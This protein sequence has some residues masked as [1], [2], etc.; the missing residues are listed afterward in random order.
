MAQFRVEF[1]IDPVS[2]KFVAE[3]YNPDDSNQLIGRTEAVYPTQ[4]SALLGVVDLF[5]LALLPRPAAKKATPKKKRAA[6][7]PS[8]GRRSP[9]KGSRRRASRRR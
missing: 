6:K 7:R 2:G 5:K 4:A 9:R 3:L 1:V 8:A